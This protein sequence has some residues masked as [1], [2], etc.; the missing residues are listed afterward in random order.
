M[1]SYTARLGGPN[2]YGE[3]RPLEQ[4]GDD[5]PGCKSEPNRRTELNVQN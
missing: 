2:G 5:F 4:K 3:T 1:Y